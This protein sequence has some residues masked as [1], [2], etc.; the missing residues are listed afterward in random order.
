MKPKTRYARDGDVSIAYQVFGDGSV[1]LVHMWGPATH[2][3]HMWDQP[4]VPASTIGLAGS[5]AW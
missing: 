3:E 5:R 2:I 1:D 4:R